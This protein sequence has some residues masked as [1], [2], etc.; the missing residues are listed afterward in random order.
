MVWYKGRLAGDTVPPVGPP[1]QVLVPAPLAAERPPV[2]VHGLPAALD[3]QPRLAHPTH[4]MTT[5][6]S[7]QWRHMGLQFGRNVVH[8]GS[9]ICWTVAIAVLP[10]ATV[11][12]LEFI[13]PAWVTLLAVLFLG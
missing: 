2:V 5:P 10:L 7:V 6:R 8:F 13:I 1:R 9:Q 11:F 4:S 12:A 3:A